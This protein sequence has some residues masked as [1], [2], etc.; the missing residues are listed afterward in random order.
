MGEDTVMTMAKFATESQMELI[1]RHILI[2]ISLTSLELDKEQLREMNFGEIYLAL[3]ALWMDRLSKLH[4]DVRKAIKADG[5]KVNVMEQNKEVGVRAEYW[6]NKYRYEFEMI[7][8]YI[9]AEVSVLLSEVARE[10]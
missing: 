2:P 1:K 4:A 9:K 7:P 8:N 6:V 3:N 5:I 10:H